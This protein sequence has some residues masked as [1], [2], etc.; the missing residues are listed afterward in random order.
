VKKR[1]IAVPAVAVLLLSLCA[2]QLKTVEP[3]QFGLPGSTR[4]RLLSGS[5]TVVTQR[6]R[7]FRG[8]SSDGVTAEPKLRI[9]GVTF[10]G[11]NVNLVIDQSLSREITVTADANIIELIEV[12]GHDEIVISPTEPGLRFSPTELTITVGLPI[13]EL[14]IEGAWNISYASYHVSGFKAKISGAAKGDF[15]FGSAGDAENVEFILD[16]ACDIALY[17]E[18]R[19]AQFTVNGASKVAAY[20]LAAR[21]AAVVINGVGECQLAAAESLDATINGAG[22]IVYDGSPEVRKSI[23]GIGTVRARQE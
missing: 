5:G 23:N 9:S 21:E 15:T 3:F 19:R 20:G 2:C 18:A 8:S 6:M 17:G 16:G 14:N 7:D 10:L 4:G 1:I 11:G 22:S 12:T 13:S